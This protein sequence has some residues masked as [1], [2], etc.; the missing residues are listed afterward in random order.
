MTISSHLLRF[1]TRIMAPLCPRIILSDFRYSI[2][3][4]ESDSS[5][6]LASHFFFETPEL[7]F[8]NPTL[9]NFI[10]QILYSRTTP[11]PNLLGSQLF[12]SLILKCPSFNS[13]SLDHYIPSILSF[14]ARLRAIVHYDDHS[15]TTNHNNSALSS[16]LSKPQVLSQ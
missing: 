5:N 13:P 16:I 10:S 2:S 8:S 7:S 12:N 3:S 1:D 6:I 4:C 9:W 15:V 14:P 11:W